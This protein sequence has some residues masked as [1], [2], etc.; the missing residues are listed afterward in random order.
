MTRTTWAILA[1]CS[2]WWLAMLH[3]LAQ[4]PEPP[5]QRPP[6]LFPQGQGQPLPD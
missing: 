2:F 1:A 4:V 3:L 6:Y 5:A